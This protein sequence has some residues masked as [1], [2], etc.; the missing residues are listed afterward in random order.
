MASHSPPA[1]TLQPNT[2]KFIRG[3]TP[4]SFATK[5]L[6]Y[7]PYALFLYS[8]V[9]SLTDKQGLLPI[10]T[11]RQKSRLRGGTSRS[12]QASRGPKKLFGGVQLSPISTTITA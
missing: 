2:A 11:L 12:S 3:Q 9:Y 5:Q 1:S 4:L 8:F 6:R 10:D 7:N